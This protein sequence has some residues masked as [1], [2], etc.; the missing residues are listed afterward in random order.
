MF[1]VDKDVLKRDQS[2][3]EATGW[4]TH[5]VLQRCYVMHSHEQ[6]AR[7]VSKKLQRNLSIK[8]LRIKYTSLIRT[9]PAVPAT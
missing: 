3:G 7:V 9:L 1:K 5:S 4:G 2:F 8:E 6:L